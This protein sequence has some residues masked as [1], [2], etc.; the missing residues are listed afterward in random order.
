M[1]REK[2]KRTSMTIRRKG[3]VVLIE[4]DVSRLQAPPPQALERKTRAIER[5]IWKEL[6]TQ[7]QKEISRR[8]RDRIASQDATIADLRERLNQTELLWRDRA[9][10]MRSVAKELSVEIESLLLRLREKKGCCADCG[11]T[12]GHSKG[13]V[14]PRFDEFD[15]PNESDLVWSY[16]DKKKTERKTS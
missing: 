12:S 2:T 6:R 3:D 5:R 11:W 10:A 9:F 14:V 4:V 8:A 16:E 7:Q 15:I 1:K 13:C